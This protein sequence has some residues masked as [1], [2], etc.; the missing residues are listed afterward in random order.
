[1]PCGDN[2]YS[3]ASVVILP[4][5]FDRTS[6]WLKGSDKGPE[7]LIEASRHLEFYDIET[8][9]KVLEKGVFTADPVRTASSS[10]M[11]KKTGAAVSRYL[12]E[13]KLVV[14][15]GGEHSVSIG[16]IRSFA[17]HYKGLSILHLDAHADSRD[18]Y[19][20]SRYNHACV[21]AR[22]RESTGNIVSVGIRSMD[23]SELPGIDGKRIFFAHK[24]HD[25]DK[26]IDSAVELLT[27]TVYITIDL[28][29]FDPGIMPSTGTPEPGGLGW[30]QVL[31]LLRAV[32]I[33]K[34][35]V[36]FDVVELCPSENKAP[37]F[38]AAKLVF[39]LLSY[40]YAGDY[41]G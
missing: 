24:I 30:Y 28:D 36:G 18:S 25:S 27:D 29:V 11:I 12:K 2:D 34:R 32:S 15:L 26:W 16:V 39:T 31:K 17:G 37:D 38:L 3:R 23:S 7:A 21:M 33:S 22:A 13:N 8:D 6:T 19:E 5:P 14:T 41:H 20:G 40:I 9:S 4:V 35:I 10:S 1:M